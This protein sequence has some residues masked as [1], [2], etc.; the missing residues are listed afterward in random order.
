MIEPAKRA[1]AFTIER[2]RPLRGLDFVLWMANLGLAPQALCLR[3]LR[4]LI[5]FL[6][7]ANLG[8]APQALCLRLLRRLRQ[9]LSGYQHERFRDR[10]AVSVTTRVFDCEL[11]VAACQL[12]WQPDDQ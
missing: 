1:A 4:R 2:C 12:F 7:M 6:L 11:D 3:L 5:S 8:L 9:K 10:R